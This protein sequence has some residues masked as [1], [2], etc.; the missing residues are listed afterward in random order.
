MITHPVNQ[1]IFYQTRIWI[2]DTSKG[3]QDF[4]RIQFIDKIFQLYSCSYDVQVIGILVIT[5]DDPKNIEG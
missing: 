4:R 1:D 5:E 2:H 3:I